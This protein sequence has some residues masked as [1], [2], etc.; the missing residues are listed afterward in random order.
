[1]NKLV[2]RRN[3]ARGSVGVFVE[4]RRELPALPEMSLAPDGFRCNLEPNGVIPGGTGVVLPEADGV[5][6]LQ[7][8]NEKLRK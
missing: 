1:M 2:Y 5:R 7:T 6:A 8:K 3:G 4:P